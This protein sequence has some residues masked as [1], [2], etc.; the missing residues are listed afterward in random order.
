MLGAGNGHRFALRPER[1]GAANKVDVW[2]VYEKELERLFDVGSHRSKQRKP[3]F[4]GSV[5]TDTEFDLAALQS[6]KATCRSTPLSAISK[7]AGSIIT[8]AKSSIP[9]P[10][11]KMLLST[12]TPGCQ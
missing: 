4:P 11:T 12:R 9:A 6:I 8:S 3:P 1:P 7:R 10:T 5:F 2:H